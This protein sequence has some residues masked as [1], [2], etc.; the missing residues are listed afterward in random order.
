MIK[1]HFKLLV[2]LDGPTPGVADSREGTAKWED[3]SAALGDE[4][5]ISPIYLVENRAY[6]CN[7]KKKKKIL[8][9]QP[10]M[11]TFSKV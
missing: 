4:C 1:V 10:I 7:V 3:G 8:W 2:T 9:I 5:N 6:A 11:N